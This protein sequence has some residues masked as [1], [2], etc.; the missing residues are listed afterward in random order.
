MHNVILNHFC[1]YV[2]V[3][4]LVI[5]SVGTVSTKEDISPSARRAG[6]GAP[7]GAVVA[8]PPLRH[9]RHL[10]HLPGATQPAAARQ[11]TTIVWRATPLSSHGW[12]HEVH[13]Y[14]TLELSHETPYKNMKHENKT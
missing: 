2:T 3:I 4:N 13:W 6:P 12:V 14:V 9:L 8:L 5:V 1:L 10:P 11:L 7:A